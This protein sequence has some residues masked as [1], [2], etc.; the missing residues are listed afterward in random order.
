MS[1]DNKEA[2][3]RWWSSL[4]SQLLVGLGQVFFG[5]VLTGMVLYLVAQY[6]MGIF[7]PFGLATVTGLLGGFPLVAAFGERVDNQGLR[8]KLKSIGGLY[9][10]AAICFVVFGFYQAADYAKLLPQTG[11]GVWQFK[12]I[13]V[14]TF[15]G[16][17]IALI[18]GMWMTLGIIP[19]LMGLGDINDRVRKIFRRSK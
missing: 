5:I 10:L 1:N 8:N 19:Q 11:A 3:G 18:L 17:A 2:K 15:Y 16:G 12:V 7:E 13:Y 6:K 9:L 4:W 14:V